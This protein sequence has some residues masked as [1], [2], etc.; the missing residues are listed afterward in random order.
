MFHTYTGRTQRASLAF[1]TTY[2]ATN[3][4]FND[5][6]ARRLDITR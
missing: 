5:V 4:A 6:E 1:V 2:I 3:T